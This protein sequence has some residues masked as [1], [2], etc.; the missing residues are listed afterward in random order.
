MY[1]GH[2]KP[3]L[4]LSW[5]EA[6]PTQSCTFVTDGP[7]ILRRPLLASAAHRPPT[8]SSFSRPSYIWPDIS[9]SLVGLAYVLSPRRCAAHTAVSQKTLIPILSSRVPSLCRGHAWRSVSSI[10]V[11]LQCVLAPPRSRLAPCFHQTRLY[12]LRLT[13][14][15]WCI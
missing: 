15:L 1:G 4:S 5:I 14:E 3:C 9:D 7:S 12:T 10:P 6:C 11:Q 13:A 8:Y 2:N